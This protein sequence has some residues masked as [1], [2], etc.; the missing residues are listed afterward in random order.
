MS[1]IMLQLSKNEVLQEIDPSLFRNIPCK[2]LQ[3]VEENNFQ[4]HS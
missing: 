3:Q 2:I 1:F 4:V